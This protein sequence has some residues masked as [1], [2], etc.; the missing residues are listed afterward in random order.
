M[1]RTTILIIV[2]ALIAGATLIGWLYFRAN[3]VMKLIADGQTFPVNTD[4]TQY[5]YNYR[6]NEELVRWMSNQYPLEQ[7]PNESFFHGGATWFYRQIRDTRVFAAPTAMRRDSY[8]LISAG[9]DGLY[10][11]EDDIYNFERN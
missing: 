2:I 9:H 6:D 5:T 7:I 4:F 10:G 3:P 1:R 8:I 11:T